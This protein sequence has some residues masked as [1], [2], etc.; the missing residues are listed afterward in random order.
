MDSLEEAIDDILALAVGDVNRANL[1]Y[2]L[3]GVRLYAIE[4]AIAD[5][6]VIAV[7]DT[8]SMLEV[9]RP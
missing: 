2:I 9:L 7:D 4:A 3:E 6:E 1:S 8:E 5:G